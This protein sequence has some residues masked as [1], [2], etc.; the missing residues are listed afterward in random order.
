MKLLTKAFYG[1]F[2]NSLK[3]PKSRTL[4]ILASLFYLFSPIDISTD[5]IPV[6]GWLDDGLIL[7]I[8]TTELAQLALDSRQKRQANTIIDDLDTTQIIDVIAQ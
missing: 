1:W 5:I 6:I 7:T 2:R 3:N 8:L 4:I